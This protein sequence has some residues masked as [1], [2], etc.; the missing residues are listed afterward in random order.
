MLMLPCGT[1][2]N[3]VLSEIL[4]TV[5]EVGHNTDIIDK[6]H[7]TMDASAITGIVHNYIGVERYAMCYVVHQEL[8]GNYYRSIKISH[9]TWELLRT[10]MR[11]YWLR[12]YRRN[13]KMNPKQEPKSTPIA[14]G[15]AKMQSTSHRRLI[16]YMNN[17]QGKNF[18]RLAAAAGFTLTKNI[19]GYLR[20]WTHPDGSE[21]HEGRYSAW[22]CWLSPAVYDKL[23]DASRRIRGVLT[24]ALD[25]DFMA[26]V[27][28]SHD[29]ESLA[30][31]YIGY[32][33]VA[34]GIYSK[35]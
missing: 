13:A 23:R 20:R 6:Y 22:V 35:D 7:Y 27:K 3:F 25:K 26:E 8:P 15:S 17:G 4:P 30:M 1:G 2:D 33:E 31:S 24:H 10:T 16:I 12:L 14:L 34:Y 29:N 18:N 32:H 11:D 21:L 9:A 5:F 19:K 28:R